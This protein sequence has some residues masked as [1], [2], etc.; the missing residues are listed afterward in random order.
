M[1]EPDALDDFV[2]SDVL[3]SVAPGGTTKLNSDAQRRANLPNPAS[4]ERKSRLEERQD[5]H[6]GS[7][8]RREMPKLNEQQQRPTFLKPLENM[9]QIALGP[10]IFGV[11]RNF[12]TY[13][14]HVL[15]GVLSGVGQ[16][17][18]T[19]KLRILADI[20]IDTFGLFVQWMYTESLLDKNLEP[21]YQHRLMA[22]WILAKRL[23]IPKLQND[24]IDML[25]ERRQME[26]GIQDKTSLMCIR[27]PSKG[28]PCGDIW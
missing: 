1:E 11:Y 5:L 20:D 15:A 22:L 23:Q 3:N 12:L 16:T 4:F 17:T 6:I 25:E 8:A 19:L 7:N 9:V 2:I 27:I 10:H 26:G 21:A 28:I 18:S 24:S 13:H 14:S